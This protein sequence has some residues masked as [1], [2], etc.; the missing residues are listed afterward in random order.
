TKRTELNSEKIQSDLSDAKNKTR[1]LQTNINQL[2]IE[3]ADSRQFIST[4]EKRISELNNSL[5]T[6]QVLGE[7]PLTHCPQCLSELNNNVADGH[8][9]LCKQPLP[10]EAEKANAKRLLQRNGFTN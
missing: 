2:D 3:I 7:L 4:L 6:R 8:C 10:E 1:I 9:F 5:L